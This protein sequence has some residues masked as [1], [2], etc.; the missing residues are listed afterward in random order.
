MSRGPAFLIVVVLAVVSSFGLGSGLPGGLASPGVSA[1]VHVRLLSAPAG[2]GLVRI[3]VRFSHAPAGVAAAPDG[4]IFAAHTT[5]PSSGPLVVIHYIPGVGPV[6]RS[7][8]LRGGR[9]TYGQGR[10]AEAG[11]AVWVLGRRGT[12]GVGLIR[13]LDTRTLRSI[14]G[15]RVPGHPESI[16]ATT[17]GVWVAVGRSLFR[18]DAWSGARTL[19]TSLSGTITHI[20]ASPDGNLLYVTTRGPTLPDDSVPLLELSAW[21]G[22]ILHRATSCCADLR[23]VSSL[24]ATAAGVWAT[25]PTGMMGGVEFFRWEDLARRFSPEG[26]GGSNGVT[27]AVGGGIV[28]RLDAGH[29]TCFGPGTGKNGLL[30]LTTM[31]P[32][33]PFVTVPSGIYAAAGGGLARVIAQPACR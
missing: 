1:P 14:G 5:H 10:I 15:V 7:H 33:P 19:S 13:R 30:R 28:W 22:E 16:V 9:S 4:S 17:A 21:S 20:A 11:G 23:G 8:P 2:K 29:V 6:A 27:V 31:P 24:A 32:A 18:L 3:V 25:F 26:E 12:G